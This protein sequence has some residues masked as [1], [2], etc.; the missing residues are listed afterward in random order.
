MIVEKEPPQEYRFLDN[1]TKKIEVAKREI[2]ETA[3][4]SETRW[5]NRLIGDVVVILRNEKEAGRGKLGQNIPEILKGEHGHEY[6]VDENIAYLPKDGEVVL[7]GDT[8]GDPEGIFSIL[9]QTEFIE[10]MEKGDKKMKLVFLGDYIDR[11]KESLKTINLVLK[12]KRRY[13]NNII[14]LRGNHE[15]R[16]QLMFSN[17]EFSFIKELRGR[18]DKNEENLLEFLKGESEA[19]RIFDN[20]CRFFEK[21]PSVLVTGNGLIAVHGGAPTSAV[22]SL[23]ELNN[24]EI[25]REMRNNDP[26]NKYLGTGE[27]PRR[28]SGAK[29]FGKDHFL[30]FMEKVG[31]TVMAR[32]HEMVLK[33]GNKIASTMFGDRLVTIFSNGG[34]KSANSAYKGPAISPAFARFPLEEPITHWEDKHFQEIRY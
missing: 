27:N 8:H 20:F 10:K 16:G 26:T 31:A 13:P 4:E 3:G 5:I 17:T 18:F 29:A 6:F 34:P 12:L 24:K 19:G 21:L 33:K 22:S 25:L 1:P 7:V 30:T 32:S 9:E 11:G 15:A 28:G 23:N 14:L 2:Y